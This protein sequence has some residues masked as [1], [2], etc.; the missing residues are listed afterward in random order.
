MAAPSGI[1]D[2][3]LDPQ[4]EREKL[5]TEIGEVGI[6]HVAEQQ[7]G[8]GVEDFDVHKEVGLVLPWH[9]PAIP[10]RDRY[11]GE[12]STERRESKFTALAKGP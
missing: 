2:C 10:S 7:L 12:R 8:A 3:L 6:C 11:G 9:A 1:V 5:L 4:S